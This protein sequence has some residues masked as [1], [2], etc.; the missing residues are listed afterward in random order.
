MT[1]EL[2]DLEKAEQSFF[3]EVMSIFSIVTLGLL[4]CFI[5]AVVYYFFN[6]SG[7]S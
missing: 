7:L 5:L 2:D 1:K 3:G 6:K 4:G